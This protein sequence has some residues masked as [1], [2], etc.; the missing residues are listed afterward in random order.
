MRSWILPVVVVFS[1]VLLFWSGGDDDRWELRN[2]RIGAGP[3]VAFGDSLTFGH[4]A[5]PGESYPDLLSRR[6]GREIVN[7]G[8]NGD[9]AAEALGRLERDVLSLEPS[10][11]LITL[12]GND[13]LRKV[14]VEE[15][16]AAMREIFSRTLDAGSTVVFLSIEPPFVAGDRLD[17]VREIARELGVM[18]ISGVMEGLWGDRDRMADRIHPNGDGYRVIAERV[19][20]ALRERGLIGTG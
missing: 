17:A 16:A 13:M 9:T 12:G 4:G 20:E 1:A 6:I 11:V 8:R 18:W 5:P 3:I 7:R 15:T 19:D 10:A 14:P 2:P